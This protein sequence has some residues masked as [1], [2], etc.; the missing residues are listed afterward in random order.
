M[1]SLIYQNDIAA[2]NSSQGNWSIVHLLLSAPKFGFDKISSPIV[3]GTPLKLLD[4]IQSS[5]LSSLNLL[6]YIVL[7]EVD[8]LIGSLGKYASNDAKR[9]A[10]KN[11][12]PTI[13]LLKCILSTRTINS[14][15]IQIV[16]SS[17]TV[18]RPLRREL[19][20]IIQN[21][22][23]M[24]D[25][26]M[27][28]EDETI[29]NGDFPVIRSAEE[30]AYD[31][32]HNII[33]TTRDFLNH[34]NTLNDK[35]NVVIPAKRTR[36]VGIPHSIRH[37]AILTDDS[38]DPLDGMTKR[39]ALAKETWQKCTPMRSLLFVPRMEDV[40][41]VLGILSFW[42]VKEATSLQHILGVD[43]Y[44]K[45]P[46]G[47]NVKGS[48]LG[49]GTRRFSTKDIIG[50]ASQHGIG[51]GY[52]TDDDGIKILH[53]D[54]SGNRESK[55]K[56]EILVLPVTGARGLHVQGVDHVFV[57]YTPYA[58]DE[59][60]HMAGRTGRVGSSGTV[61]SFVNMDQLKRLQSWQTPLGISFEVQVA[62]Q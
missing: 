31:E 41:Q 6:S 61:T 3:V 35:S 45:S 55:V 16:A 39:L 10:R 21:S 43:T 20:R 46:Q 12:N 5:S 51:S 53:E 49:P 30:E 7:D 60:L 62:K 24:R 38:D 33:P 9:N 58:M 26:D 15:D 40:R 1:S 44:M 47:V 14:N 32:T 22:K 28:H 18:G 59:Y 13:D 50:K 54:G 37:I 27:D 57:L 23:Q 8:C 34:R 42:G 29:E 36:L 2:V 52:V 48:L 4:A 17:A 56:G 25:N 19:F 11:N